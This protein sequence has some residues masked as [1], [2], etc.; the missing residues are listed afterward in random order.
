MNLRAF[1][2]RTRAGESK[3]MSKEFR[4]RMVSFRLTEEEYDRL[5][6][7]CYV[8][9]IRSV[10]DLARAGI[11]LLLQQPDRATP[12]TLESRVTEIES[13]LRILSL[14]LRRMTQSGITIRGSSLPPAEKTTKTE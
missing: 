7:L 3:P 4:S 9:G 12:E 13:R 6:Q 14:E 1:P 11:N 5:H 2:P 10:S 8:Q